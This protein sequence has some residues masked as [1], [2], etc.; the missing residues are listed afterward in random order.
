MAYANTV[1]VASSAGFTADV[2]ALVAAN[3]GIFLLGLSWRESAGSAAVATFQVVNGATGAATGK[4]FVAEVAA[5]GSGW[6]WFG[7]QGIPCP[8]G[9][10]IDHIA[11]TLDVF[12]YYKAS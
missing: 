9:I 3:T 12:V 6:A 11:G 10:S 5:N 7:P 2:D 1:T 4:V 8:L